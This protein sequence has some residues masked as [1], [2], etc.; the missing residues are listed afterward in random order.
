MA[1]NKKEEEVPVPFIFSGDDGILSEYDPALT[2]APHPLTKAIEASPMGIGSLGTLVKIKRKDDETQER[3]CKIISKELIKKP[4]KFKL[5]VQA[6]N[7]LNQ[8]YISNLLDVFE[9]DLNVYLVFDLCMSGVVFDFES[10]M[11]VHKF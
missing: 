9:D 8:T 2:Y 4:E 11:M 10:E 3:A 6:I 7:T 1:E 5:D